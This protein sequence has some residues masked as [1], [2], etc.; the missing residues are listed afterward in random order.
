LLTT[1]RG[2]LVRL[3]GGAPQGKATTFAGRIFYKHAHQL[4]AFKDAF[5]ATAR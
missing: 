3:V 2:E 1:R 4:P 5:T